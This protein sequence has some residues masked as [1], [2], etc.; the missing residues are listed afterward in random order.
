MDNSRIEQ[1]KREIRY[2]P[3]CAYKWRIGCFHNNNNNEALNQHASPS[4]DYRQ[5]KK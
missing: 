5:F 1:M 4:L 3:P 2:Q